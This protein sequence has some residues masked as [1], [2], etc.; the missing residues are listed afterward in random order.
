MDISTHS[1]REDGDNVL[2]GDRFLIVD[3]NPLRPQGRRPFRVFSTALSR[4]FQPTPPARTETIYRDKRLYID[5]FQPTP[6]TRTET[7]FRSRFLICRLFQP[8]P[9]TRTETTNREGRKVYTT[10]STHSAHEDGD[11]MEPGDTDEDVISTH[12]AHEDGDCKN[13]NMG[14]VLPYFNPLRPRGRRRYMPMVITRY[15]HFNPLRPRGRRHLFNS[16]VMR[17]GYFNPL[18][19]RGRRR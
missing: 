12:S 10:I 6:P 14:P 7:G 3:F 5:Q 13:G 9:P 2:S 11:K 19:P 8:T 16:R 1:A 17:K 15:R 4:R 18:R